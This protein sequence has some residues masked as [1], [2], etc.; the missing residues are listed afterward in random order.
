M[1]PPQC[2]CVWLCGCDDLI[3]PQSD[4]NGGVDSKRDNKEGGNEVFV[5]MGEGLRLL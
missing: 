4:S 2:L 5:L 1:K 3:V